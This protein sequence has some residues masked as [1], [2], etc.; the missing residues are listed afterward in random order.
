[1]PNQNLCSTLY[2]KK[3]GQQRST[4]SVHSLKCGQRPYA[5]DVREGNMN[6]YI[7]CLEHEPMLRVLSL[8]AYDGHFMIQSNS[9]VSLNVNRH[10]TQLIEIGSLIFA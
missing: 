5:T 10:Q 4:F 6:K 9:I 1:M 2:T 7:S 8:F 3:F